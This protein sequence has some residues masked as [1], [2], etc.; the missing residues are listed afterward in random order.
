MLVIRLQRTGRSNSPAYRVV[1]AEKT[2]PVKGKSVEIVGHY[3]PTREDAPFE[4]NTDRVSFW[5]ERGAVPSDTVARL[6]A[7]QGVAGLEKFI[8]RYTKKKSKKEHPE[9]E[10]PA[11]APAPEASGDDA[12]AADEPASEEEA[13]AEEPAPEATQDVEEPKEEPASPDPDPSPAEDEG[14][15][16][17]KAE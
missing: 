17:E 5:M 14:D 4:V 12:P 8:K 15:K 10:A 13:P 6:L 1:V 3:L 7:K 2:A 16:E 9:E 11:A